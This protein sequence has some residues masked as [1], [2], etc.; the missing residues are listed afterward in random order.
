MSVDA[1]VSVF[2]CEIAFLCDAIENKA[3]K[4]MDEYNNQ[5]NLHHEQM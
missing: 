2:L 3:E 5:A 1:C 4:G